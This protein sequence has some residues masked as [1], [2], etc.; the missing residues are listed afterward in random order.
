MMVYILP[1]MAKGQMG[2]ILVFE[3]Y[4]P[5]ALSTYNVEFVL[6]VARWT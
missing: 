1:S 4:P 6:L 3:L 5:P 2:P